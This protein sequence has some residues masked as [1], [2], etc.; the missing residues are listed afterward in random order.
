MTVV[1]PLER[2]AAASFTAVPRN[3]PMPTDWHAYENVMAPMPL[4]YFYKKFNLYKLRG[5]DWSILDTIR[6][7]RELPVTLRISLSKA[8]A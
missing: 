7:G 1:T 5:D 2:P 4:M 3:L 6:A 8:L